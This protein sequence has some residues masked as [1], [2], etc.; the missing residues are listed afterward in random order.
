LSPGPLRDWPVDLAGIHRDRAIP[1]AVPSVARDS[2]DLPVERIDFDVLSDRV[3][4]LKKA[5]GDRLV[6]DSDS[7]GVR[8]I[9]LGE[10][11]SALDRNLERREIVGAGGNHA[12][13]VAMSRPF[14]LGAAN[15]K[16]VRAGRVRVRRT[17]HRRCSYDPR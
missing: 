15:A 6:D 8:S 11:A 14:R 5:A 10:G 1:R 13:A 2:D 12:H 4:V 17:V 9:S 16:A 7:L 3:R